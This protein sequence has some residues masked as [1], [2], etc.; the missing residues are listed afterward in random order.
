MSA[1]QMA[2]I[3]AMD[4]AARFGMVS[5]D[6]LEWRDGSDAIGWEGTAWYGGDYNK[7][8]LKSE[9]E[10]IEDETTHTRTELL[11]DRVASRWWS[12]QA[13][14]RHDSGDGPSRTWAALGAEGLAPYWIDMEATLYVGDAGR[15][16]VRFEGSHDMRVTQRLIL[17]PQ[18]E[19]NAYGKD[20]IERGIGSGL[21]DLEAG[22]RLRYE[23]RREFAPYIG[24]H[25]KRLF[26]GTADLASDDSESEFVAGFKVWF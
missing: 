3:M 15:T 16:A 10:W 5:I 17:Q 12:V 1:A 20:D 26:G 23:I 18:L 14:L 13:G 24:V 8:V 19:F 7:L 25:W 6:R 2:E 11:W 21:S 4:D 22:L 9:G